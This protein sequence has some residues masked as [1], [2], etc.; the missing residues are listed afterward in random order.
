MRPDFPLSHARNRGVGDAEFLGHSNSSFGRSSNLSDL[1]LCQ[2][3]PRVRN[4][5]QW[6]AMPMPTL[7]EAISRVIGICSKKQ[8]IWI[9]A[10]RAVAFVANK[11]PFRDALAVMQLPRIPMGEQVFALSLRHGPVSKLTDCPG[12]PPAGIFSLDDVKKVVATSITKPLQAGSGNK[13]IGTKRTLSED[14]YVSSSHTI[15]LCFMFLILALSR[16][17]AQGTIIQ[18]GPITSFHLGAFLSN[19]VI[20]DAG[21]SNAPATGLLS[22]F[23]GPSCPLSVASSTGPGLLTGQYAQLSICQTTA[24]TIFN[25]NSY[26]GLASPG[27]EFIV[28]GVI[29]PFPGGSGASGT[30]YIVSTG[31][32]DT[33]APASLAGFLTVAWNSPAASAKT[34]NLPACNG[35][36]AWK[37]VTVADQFGSASPS[38][39]IVVVSNGSD[40][41]RGHTSFYIQS[42]YETDD[43]QCNGAGVWI[44]K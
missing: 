40:S 38:Q 35:S 1:I 29:Y 27:I 26:N 6:L 13:R 34:E 8:V 5:L 43:F 18:S 10:R 15:A 16:C 19:G 24:N 11:K 17:N 44:V 28:N 22:M 39:P 25:I 9:C 12:P 14:V 3:R 30:G 42:A 32:T 4:A 31:N 21:N 36:L 33:I 2:L 23:N 20:M 7:C 41:I 37:V